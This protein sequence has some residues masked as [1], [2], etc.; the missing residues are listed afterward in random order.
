MSRVPVQA[1]V[2]ADDT[3][4]MAFS[5]GQIQRTTFLS[6]RV[7]RQ[8]TI[9]FSSGQVNRVFLYKN[10]IFQRTKLSARADNSGQRSF[11]H[12][13]STFF[14][15]GQVVRLADNFSGQKSFPLKLSAN[16]KTQRR[17]GYPNH[18]EIN[19][20]KEKSS[21]IDRTRGGVSRKNLVRSIEKEGRGPDR[22][23]KSII[24]DP[25]NIQQ[26]LNSDLIEENVMDD[27]LK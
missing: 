8:R 4:T 18:E 21:S 24:H 13:T 3:R 11:L 10:V 5:S 27:G 7:V 9:L 12:W 16:F 1:F 15:S 17:G 25:L 22:S 26:N 6:A 20:K 2:R 23:N 19:T 14:S